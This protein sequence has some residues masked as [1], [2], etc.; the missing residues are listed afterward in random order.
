[1]VHGCCDLDED[2]AEHVHPMIPAL[3]FGVMLSSPRDIKR[4]GAEV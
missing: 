4:W 2:L 3:H 1:M